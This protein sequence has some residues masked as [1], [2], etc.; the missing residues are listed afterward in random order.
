MKQI[1]RTINKMTAAN[2]APADDA[3]VTTNLFSS[4]LLMA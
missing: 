1:A 3:I 4:D 2:P